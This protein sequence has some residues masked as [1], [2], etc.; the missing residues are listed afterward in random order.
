MP[1]LI[2]TPDIE[3]RDVRRRDRV[4]PRQPDVERD[5]PGLRAEAHEQQHEDQVAQRPERAA[6]AV[7]EGVERGGAG[8]GREHREGDD[9]RRRGEVREGEVQVARPATGGSGAGPKT[10]AAELS[11][12]SSQ[13]NRNAK[14]SSA[15][16]TRAR[17]PRNTG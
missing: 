17:L 8:G 3:G 16:K 4:R 14:A 10:S 15:P 9:E 6:A 1:A 12:I 7:A 13:A 2:M 11:A 5:R